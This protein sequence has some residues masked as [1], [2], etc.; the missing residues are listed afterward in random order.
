MSRQVVGS[1]HRSISHPAN[2]Q[3]NLTIIP[4]FI[5]PPP[6]SP[7]HNTSSSMESDTNSNTT[8]YNTISQ[9]N[10]SDIETHDKFANSQPDSSTLFQPP[11]QPIRSQAKIELPS[12]PSLISIVIT[13]YSPLTS[14]PSDNNDSE[15][16]QISHELDKIITLHQQLQHPQTLTIHQISRPITPSNPSTPISSST[17]TPSQ[18]PTR[19]STP[20]SSTTRAY[21][22]FKRKFP[23]F[24]FLSNPRTSTSFVNHPLHTNTEEILQ[25]CLNFFPQNTCFHP[26][27]ND[28]KPI[29][30]SE[31]VLYPTF[32][33]TSHYHFTNPLSMPLYNTPYDNEV[34]STQLY[35]LTQH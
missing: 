27:P 29:Y 12:P 35:L 13:I 7:H 23:N 28:E 19:S 34:C 8:V 2:F 3:N 30:V 32:S 20:S 25:T 21:R 1:L 11:F 18:N 9:F 15:N 31:R 4:L 14:E 10:N 24:P 6:Q 5:F 33:W 16:T 22:T 17:H 26:G